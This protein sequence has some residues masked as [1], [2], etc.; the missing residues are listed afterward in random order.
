MFSK[1]PIPCIQSYIGN[2]ACKKNVSKPIL[3]FPNLS[4]SHSWLF[5]E[6]IIEQ[7]PQNRSWNHSNIAL[8]PQEGKP[9]QQKLKLLLQV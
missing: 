1:V 8:H 5:S 9:I 4:I 2:W 3:K 7:K 6:K